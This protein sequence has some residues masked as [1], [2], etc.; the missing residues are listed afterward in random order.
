MSAQTLECEISETPHWC[1]VC[2]EKT[3]SAECLPRRCFGSNPPA[4]QRCAR[5]VTRTLSSNRRLRKL[6]STTTIDT[7]MQVYWKTPEKDI[8]PR[9][10]CANCQAL[11]PPGTVSTVFLRTLMP[12]TARYLQFQNQEGTD[13]D[14]QGVL[15]L[16]HLDMRRMLCGSV[17]GVAAEAQ[18]PYK[19]KCN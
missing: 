18:I 12:N 17:C 14:I 5:R 4:A 15:K 19:Y 3:I 6:R 1:G 16:Q 7:P 10:K 8:D 11:H 2:H 9:M 13:S